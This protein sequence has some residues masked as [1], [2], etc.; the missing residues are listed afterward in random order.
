MPTTTTGTN[1]LKPFELR[2]NVF[3]H[4]PGPGTRPVIPPVFRRKFAVPGFLDR[5]EAVRM[6]LFDPLVAAV[7]EHDGG[8]MDLITNGVLEGGKVVA[9]ILGMVDTHDF[10][11]LFADD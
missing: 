3:N 2:V 4:D 6:V 8:F 7:G 5:N 9:G 11:V 1:D 10:L